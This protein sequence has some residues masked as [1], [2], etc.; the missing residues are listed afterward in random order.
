MARVILP[1]RPPTPSESDEEDSESPDGTSESEETSDG[2]SESEEEMPDAGEPTLPVG[3]AAEVR[4][5]DPGFAG[6]FYEVTIKGHLTSHGRRFYTIL[7]ATLVAEDGG[8]LVETVAAADVRPRPPPPREG[9]RR[10]GFALLEAVEAFHNDGW[11]AGVVSAV[12]PP[13]AAAGAPRVYEVAFPTSREKLEFEQ[14]ALRPHLVYQS[15]RWVPAAD[16]EDGSPLFPEGTQVEVSRYSEVL[17]KSWRPAC[18]LKGIGATTFL[19]QYTHIG[20][21]K[22]QVTEIIDSQYIRPVCTRLSRTSYV[23]VMHEG[24][25]WPG[26]VWEVFGSG[27]NKKYLVKLKSY[28]TDRDDTEFPELIVGYTELRPHFDWDGTKWVPIV[29]RLA[30]GFVNGTKLTSRK[31]P[32]SSAFPLYKEVGE[33][34]AKNGVR[35]GKKLKI[36]DVV[37]E[38]T[39]LLLSVENL[40]RMHNSSSYPKETSKQGDAVVALGS[41][42]APPSL[43]SMALGS[44]QLQASVFG[45]FGQPRPLPQGPLLG[46]QSLNPQTPKKGTAAKSIDEARNIVSSSADLGKQK[47]GVDDVELGYNVA[48]GRGMIS[49][50]N[51]LNCVHSTTTPN[52][53][54]GS[55]HAV[56]PQGGGSAMDKRLS[57]SLAIQHPP[58]VK[59]VP[60]W[61]QIDTMDI[62][63]KG[64]QQRPHLNQFRQHGPEFHEGMAFG[65]MISFGDLAESINRL[66]VEDDIEGL[67][68]GK[69][70]VLSVLEENGFDVGA[71]RSRIETLLY[72]KNMKTLEEKIACKET[73]DRDLAMSMRV[74]GMALHHLGL[75]T[76]F[77]R[78]MMRS[79]VTQ[80]IDNAMEISRLKSE[81]NR[82]ERSSSVSTAA[83]R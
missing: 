44:R 60:L 31:R 28:E 15:G 56:P 43:P 79:A 16:V 61:P 69:M 21:D 36:A 34:S 83:S 18:V 12:P 33:T 26:V 73:E 80:K 50:E 52:N 46:M 77:M 58:F 68:E 2:T 3:A 8:P 35:G 30:E 72:R 22:K 9:M 59:T 71:L 13:V 32:S 11:W 48:A 82:V 63:S 10:R 37:T 7:Y 54:G 1:K 24:S 25:W 76:C 27:I 67:F 19:V 78:H 20:E 64:P 51:A 81:A 49:E 39:S 29:H 40:E 14:T 41:Q 42:L 4:S 62:F 53:V 66:D 6:S 17:G 47:N 75:H 5:E 45:T 55:E 70:Q 74:L 38:A 57:E 23:E 65:L